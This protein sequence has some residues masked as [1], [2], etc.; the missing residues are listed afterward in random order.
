MFVFFL[1][2]NRKLCGHE[3]VVFQGHEYV[4]TAEF[5]KKG[6][7]YARMYTNGIVSF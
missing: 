2:T 3:S 6:H 5:L 7:E 1:H 4:Y